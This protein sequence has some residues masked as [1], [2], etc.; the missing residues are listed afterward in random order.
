MI[1]DES[2]FLRAGIQMAVEAEGDIHVAGEFAPSEDA[3]A[4]VEYLHPDV[5][6]LNLKWPDLNTIALC[7]EVRER[8]PST[9]VLI[10]SHRHDRGEMLMSL[11]AD[12]SGYLSQNSRRPEMV[13]AIRAV[14]KGETH[15]DWTV[16]QGA[17]DKLQRAAGNGL[18][19]PILDVLSE[20]EMLVLKM[21]G[22]GYTNP[23]IGQ[24]LNIAST[25]ARNH[26]ERIRIKLGVGSRPRLVSYA[27]RR[28][29]LMKP[30]EQTG[31]I[32]SLD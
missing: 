15:F 12:S 11:L 8:V 32:E 14:A 22:E 29:I 27:A 5:V 19:E 25:T 4:M 1:L 17:I 6:L 9:R 24:C 28:G 16:V 2:P 21:V 23:E 31:L 20:R 3:I 18:T 7:A 13:R 30:D 10:L 26:I